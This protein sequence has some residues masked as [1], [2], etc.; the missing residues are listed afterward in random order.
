[1]RGRRQLESPPQSRD[2]VFI[3]AASTLSQ[4]APAARSGSILPIMGAS[5]IRT[6]RMRAAM[7]AVVGLALVV[8]AWLEFEQM[9]HRKALAGIRSDVTIELAGVRYDHR[10]KSGPLRFISYTDVPA[11][12]QSDALVWITIWDDKHRTHRI[13]LGEDIP[14]TRYRLKSFE[15]G[16]LQGGSVSKITIVNKE[17]GE[18]EVLW[19]EGLPGDWE[20]RAVLRCTWMQDGAKRDCEVVRRIG[21]TFTIPPEGGGKYKVVDIKGRGA[22]VE[23][24]DGNKHLLVS[25]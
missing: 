14:G 17:T 6:S 21:E 11:K 9:R 5:D 23:R 19:R 24:P 7:W 22:V 13:R 10:E 18:E 20:T 4:L 1:M 12:E 8:V 3:L 16:K 2:T 25:K 15:R